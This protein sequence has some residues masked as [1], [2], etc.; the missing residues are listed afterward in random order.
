[1]LLDMILPDGEGGKYAELGLELS[2]MLCML[3]G[4]NA[5]LGFLKGAA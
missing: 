3:R 5:L 2:L 1:M 4:L